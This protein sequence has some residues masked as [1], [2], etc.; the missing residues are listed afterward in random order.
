MIVV[1]LVYVVYVVYNTNAI[2]SICGSTLYH[3]SHVLML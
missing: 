3:I 2:L 1:Y